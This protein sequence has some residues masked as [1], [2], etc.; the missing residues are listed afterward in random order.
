MR[1]FLKLFI[2]KSLFRYRSRLADERSFARLKSIACDTSKL[3]SCRDID[4]A[5]IFNDRN[6]EQ[7]WKNAE[8]HL[9]SL[10]ITKKA[11]GVNLGDRRALYYLVKHFK[12]KS[13]LEVGTHVGASTTHVAYALKE[14]RSELGSTCELVTVDIMDMNDP[15]TQ[16]WIRLH[17][18]LSPLAALQRL[19]AADIVQFHSEGS[20]SLLR[21]SDKLYDLIFLDGNHTATHVY[22]EIPLAL[23]RLN[24]GSYIVL[25]DYFPDLK[26]LW[27]DGRVGRGVFTAV[28]R[29]QQ[30]GADIEVVPLGDLPWPTKLGSNTTSLALL[31]RK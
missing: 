19:E 17:S 23:K 11:G 8:P 12:P 26:P 20:L 16:P 21:D 3:G 27:T 28:R 30:E 1:K 6:L 13:M 18:T 29:F 24:K 15:V 7:Q 5:S 4:L 31:G 10:E 2:P 22:Q 25:H 9:A 14:L